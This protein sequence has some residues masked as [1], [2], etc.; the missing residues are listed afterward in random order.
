MD[1][2]FVKGRLSGHKLVNTDDLKIM[3]SSMLSI[4]KPAY[5]LKT[6]DGIAFAIDSQE[7]MENILEGVKKPYMEGKKDAQAE[8]ISNVALIESQNVPVDKIFNYSQ[9]MSYITS[10]EMSS[11]K[12]KF[13]VK[14]SYTDTSTRPVKRGVTTISDPTM[15]EGESKVTTAGAD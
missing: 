9:A 12:P 8:I 14:V 3:V 10:T 2:D 11:T 4:K 13:D 15:Y 5:I 7:S 6:D 1:V